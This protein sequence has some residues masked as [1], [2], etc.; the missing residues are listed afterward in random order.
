MWDAPL[1]LPGEVSPVDLAVAVI[2]VEGEANLW[3]AEDH[4]GT[5]VRQQLLNV[6]HVGEVER[7]AVGGCERGRGEGW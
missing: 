7:L 1:N 3:V 6:C 4:R 2:A 5:T